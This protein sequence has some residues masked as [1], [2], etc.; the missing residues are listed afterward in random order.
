MLLEKLIFVKAKRQLNR[1][2][3]TQKQEAFDTNATPKPIPVPQNA[4]LVIGDT[5]KS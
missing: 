3:F 1:D 2:A 4:R 5:I